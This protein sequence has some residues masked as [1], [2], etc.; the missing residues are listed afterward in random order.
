MQP[1]AVPVVP[2]LDGVVNI[3]LVFVCA[4]AAEISGLR[5]ARTIKLSATGSV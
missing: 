1:S 2:M 4:H 3:A 5:D